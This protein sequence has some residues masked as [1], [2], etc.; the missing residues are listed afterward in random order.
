MK[1]QALST[2]IEYAQEYGMYK[3]PEIS[4]LSFFSFPFRI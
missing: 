2:Y 3:E 4:Y 1:L